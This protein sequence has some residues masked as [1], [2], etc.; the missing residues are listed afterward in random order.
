MLAG[1]VLGKGYIYLSK[2]EEPEDTH[3]TVTVVGAD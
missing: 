1:R 2:A 3:W